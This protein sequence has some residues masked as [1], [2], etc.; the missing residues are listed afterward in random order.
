MTSRTQLHHLPARLASGLF[1]AN[2]GVGKLRA[3]VDTAAR[4]HG[5]ASGTY[6]FL[7][8]VDPVVFTRGLGVAEVALGVALAVPAVPTSTAA[9]GLTAFAG[10]LLGLYART[11]GLRQEGSI[12]P[13]TEGTAVAKDVWLL[14]IGVSLLLD[15]AGTRWR[16][17]CERR[18]EPPSDRPGPMAGG[19]ARRR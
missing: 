1:I 16:D 11:P 13:S 18:R 14:G 10:G 2:S 8:S 15:R 7:R 19:R 6:P 3:D 4:V 12:R 9:A 17:R 5:M